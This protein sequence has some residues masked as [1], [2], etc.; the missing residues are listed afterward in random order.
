MLRRLIRGEN[1]KKKTKKNGH[2]HLSDD[3]VQFICNLPRRIMAHRPYTLSW[4][5][6][7]I[8]HIL[9]CKIEADEED[10]ST[11]YPIQPLDLFII[12]KYLMN[13]ECRS[14]AE[15]FLHRLL[16]S[17]KEHYKKHPLLHTFARFLHIFNDDVETTV[18]KAQKSTAPRRSSVIKNRKGSSIAQDMQI[19]DDLLKPTTKD[20]PESVLTIYLFAREEMLR[21][22]YTGAYAAPIAKAKANG[23][24]DLLKYQNILEMASM[25]PPKVIEKYTDKPVKDKRKSSVSSIAVA[26]AAVTSENATTRGNDGVLKDLCDP[27]DNADIGKKWSIKI[28]SHV[29]VF[30]DYTTW[31]PLDRATEVVLTV[32]NFLSDQQLLGVCRRIEHISAFLSPQ[33]TLSSAD[34]NHTE[35]RQHMRAFLPSNLTETTVPNRKASVNDVSTKIAAFIENQKSLDANRQYT[36]LVNLDDALQS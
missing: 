12:E 23:N 22:G 33:G 20:L 14:D 24:G 2:W 31:V 27:V 30:S 35:I 29:C 3:I 36:V 19:I 25:K 26:S 28:E 1:D 4:T 15:L 6:N 7:R 8:W 10:L 34:G 9:S 32:L 13:T 17:V 11:G 5:V 18:E 21:S 16:Q